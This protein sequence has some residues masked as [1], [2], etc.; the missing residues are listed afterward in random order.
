MTDTIKVRGIG[1]FSDLDTEEMEFTAS[2][3]ISKDFTDKISK[4]IVNAMIDNCNMTFSYTPEMDILVGLDFGDTFPSIDFYIS[5]C[6][7]RLG[8]IVAETEDIP[9]IIKSLRGCISDLEQ[10]YEQRTGKKQR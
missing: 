3:S 5:E 10:A 8:F 7:D 1:N 9:K 4:K 6:F 2:L